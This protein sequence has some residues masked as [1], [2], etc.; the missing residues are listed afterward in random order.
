MLLL[1]YLF[2]FIALQN[3]IISYKIVGYKTDR[4]KVQWSEGPMVIN[5]KCLKKLTAYSNYIMKKLQYII[6]TRTG[7][8]D[9]ITTRT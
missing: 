3:H 7:E 6:I 2:Y 4:I 5:A 9:T 8:L 1:F